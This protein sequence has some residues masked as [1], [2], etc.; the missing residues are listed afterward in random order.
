MESKNEREHCT[1]EKTERAQRITE[2]PKVIL[3]ENRGINYR[4]CH[5]KGKQNPKPVTSSADQAVPQ[6][7][8][9][10][11]EWKV[12][13]KTTLGGPWRPCLRPEGRTDGCAS[14]VQE[15]LGRQR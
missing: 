7:R 1:E 14:R 15:D 4:C 13:V 2:K 6:G 5:S 8:D 11:R 3:P 10:S 12:K 9:V